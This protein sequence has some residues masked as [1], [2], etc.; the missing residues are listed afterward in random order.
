MKAAPLGRAAAAQERAA[1]FC[2]ELRVLGYSVFTG[3]P[4]G[5]LSGVYRALD[6]SRT[7]YYPATREDLAVALAAGFALAGRRCAVLMQNSGLGVCI[8]ALLTLPVMYQLPLLL[9]IT[10]RGEGSDAPEHLAMGRSMLGLLEIAG[11]P[12][13]MATDTEAFSPE[14]HRHSSAIALIVRKGEFSE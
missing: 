4:C 7:A 3:V 8:N 14:F 6:R 10:W 5:L 9:V 11:I 13:R 1:R 2:D 12:Y